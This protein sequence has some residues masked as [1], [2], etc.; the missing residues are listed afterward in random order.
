MIGLVPALYE[1]VRSRAIT[2]DEALAHAP[3]PAQLRALAGAG[4]GR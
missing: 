2:A 4:A 3:D 1:L